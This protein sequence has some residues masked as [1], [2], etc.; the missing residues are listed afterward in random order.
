MKAREKSDQAQTRGDLADGNNMESNMQVDSHDHRWE[1]YHL[2]SIDMKPRVL[3]GTK[4]LT[5]TKKRQTW[6]L[7]SVHNVPE[8]AGV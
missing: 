3:G 7:S 8:L 4:I 2:V 1:T 5:L 6:I